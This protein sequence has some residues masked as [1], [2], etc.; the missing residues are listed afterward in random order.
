MLSVYALTGNASATLIESI[1]ALDDGTKYR[2]MFVTNGKTTATSSIISEYN[3]F[4]STEA[5][6]GSLTGGLGLSWSALASTLAVN[7]KENIGVTDTN[8]QITIF[9]TLGDIVSSSMY[10]LFRGTHAA[11]I[12][13]DQHGFHIPG[14]NYVYTGTQYTGLTSAPLGG[15]SVGSGNSFHTN[16]SPWIANFNQSD[17]SQLQSLYAISGEA[18]SSALPVPEPSIL[19]MFALG[20]AGI[21]LIRRRR[22]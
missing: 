7:V 16:S 5:A 6:E 10:D 20:L 3:T 1:A 18:T 2:V 15:G 9:N 14:N 13:S 17:P 8:D 21:G 11:D 19:A 4:V 22:Y 12:G